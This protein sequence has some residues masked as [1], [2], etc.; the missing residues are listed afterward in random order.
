MGTNYYFMQGTGALGSHIGKRTSQG[1]GRPC[2]FT[3]AISIDPA[4]FEV[5]YPYYPGLNDVV[6]EY[7]NG[8]RW[9]QLARLVEHDDIDRSH[10]GEEFS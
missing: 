5:P 4:H 7:G 8:M 9:E 2:L 3:L 1:Q 10:V 6:D